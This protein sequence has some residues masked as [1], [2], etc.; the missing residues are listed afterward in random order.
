MNVGV[1]MSVPVSAFG[2]GTCPEVELHCF[3]EEPPRRVPSGHALAS[4]AGFGLVSVCVTAI[5]VGAKC[6]LMVIFISML[7]SDIEHHFIYFLA[8]SISSQ[9][10]HSGFLPVLK[11]GCLFLLLSYTFW[12][13]IPQM[14]D[15]KILSPT[16]WV[17]FLLCRTCPLMH[18]VFHPDVIQFMCFFF[19]F[20][21]LF[22][23]CHIQDNI[24]SSNVMKLFPLVSSSGFTVLGLPFRPQI[25]LR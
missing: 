10:E 15:L 11:E 22:F 17:A 24:A 19:F 3:F 4:T 21:S 20:Y 25:H 13:S 23:W 14:C 1:H 18:R 9:E 16:P 7:M 6:R 5:R 8:I 12:I 2:S